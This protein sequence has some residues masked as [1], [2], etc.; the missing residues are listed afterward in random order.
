MYAARCKALVVSSLFGSEA[1][2]GTVRPVYRHGRV[3]SPV[4]HV[5]T[6]DDYF[7][8]CSGARNAHW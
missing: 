1:A 6:E 3:V 2:V 4:V 8:V 5:V 7:Q